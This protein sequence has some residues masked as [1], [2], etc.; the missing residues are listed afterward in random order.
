M[1]LN[2][3]WKNQTAACFT[4]LAL[5]FLCGAVVGALAMNLGVHNRLHKAAFWT[6]AGKAAYLEKVK[7]E[8]NLT[9]TQTDQMESILDDF[10]Q[11]YRTVLSDGKA[12][13]MQILNDEQKHKFERLVQESQRHP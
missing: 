9:P 11:Y 13:I 12:R 8:L 5:V 1:S 10:S 3:T 6:E 7:R 4:V 2:A